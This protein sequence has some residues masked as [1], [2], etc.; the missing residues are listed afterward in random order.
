MPYKM[1][2]TK[3]DGYTTRACN[4]ISIINWLDRIVENASVEN[5]SNKNTG[6]CGYTY[7]YRRKSYASGGESFQETKHDK[8]INLGHCRYSLIWV[9]Y[10]INN[11]HLYV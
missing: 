4:F 10:L 9:S 1:S 11:C 8:W 2:K 5:V 7:V 3:F 6:S